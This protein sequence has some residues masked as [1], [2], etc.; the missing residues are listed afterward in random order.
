M[1]PSSI[2]VFFSCEPLT[3]FP[4][5]EI[6]LPDQREK[7]RAL[8]RKCGGARRALTCRTCKCSRCAAATV[9]TDL[10]FQYPLPQHET[11]NPK[12]LRPKQSPVED[13]GTVLLVP[14][15]W[16]NVAKVAKV[17]KVA[18]FMCKWLNP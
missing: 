15:I 10:L 6:K 12:L 2:P 3:K 5:A 16:P 9:E 4:A 1:N 14:L 18:L 11:T 17:A 7:R 8:P 13:G